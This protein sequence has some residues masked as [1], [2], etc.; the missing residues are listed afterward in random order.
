MNVEGFVKCIL[1]SIFS[2]EVSGIFRNLRTF[3]SQF[4]RIHGQER[5]PPGQRLLHPFQ[6]LA[7]IRWNDFER[8]QRD[9][10]AVNRFFELL[11]NTLPGEDNE[12]EDNQRGNLENGSRRFHMNLRPRG[13]TDQREGTAVDVQ[14]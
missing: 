5:L 2:T 14:E 3:L 8:F 1:F 7:R 12:G 10:E 4:G 11:D 13:G 9:P 6:N